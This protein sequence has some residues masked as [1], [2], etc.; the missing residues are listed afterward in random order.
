MVEPIRATTRADRESLLKTAAYNL[1]LLKAED[2]TIDLLTDSGTSAM[3]AQQWGR[4][5]EGDESYAGAKSFFRFEAAFQRI[6]GF[7]YI[8]PV[9]QGR[10]AER[11]LFTTVVRKGQIVPNNT[12]F[13]TTRANLEYVGAQA[14]DLPIDEAADF[15]SPYPF[16]GNMHIPKLRELLKK[17]GPARVPLVLMTVTNNS[18]GGQPVSLSNIREASQVC[19]EFNIPFYL[20]ACRYAENAFFIKKREQSQGRRSTREIA[21]EMF[22]Y[23]Q[24]CTFSAKK[25]ALANIGGMLGL[26]SEEWARKCKNLLVLTEGF[27]TYGGLAGRDLEAIAQGV[28]EALDETYLEYRIASTTYL[29]KHVAEAGVPIVHPVG[30]HAIFIDAKAFSPH[31]PPQHFPAQALGCELYLHAGIRGVEIGSLMFGRTD[32]ESKAFV[33]SRNELLRL[34]IPRRAYTQSHIDYVVEAILD[35]YRNRDQIRGLRIVEE[36]SPLRHFTARLEPII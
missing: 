25:D 34:A 13:D 5:M 21:R 28:D 11:I 33:P 31:I 9:H 30:G 14:V 27:P 2:V 10:A 26:Q 12:H 17:E 35:V 23:A 36:T 19:R 18:L 16:K 8:L 29:G 6:M 1:F 3:S 15:E 24:G 20:D 4:M 32:P 22:S 7:K